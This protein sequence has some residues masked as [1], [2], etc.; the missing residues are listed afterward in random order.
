MKIQNIEKR[1]EGRGDGKVKEELMKLASETPEEEAQM[2]LDMEVL[3]MFKEW[4][5]KNKGGFDDF[6][7]DPEVKIQR[8]NLEGG[9]SVDFSGYSI[10]DLKAMFRSEVG[11]NPKSPQELVIVVKRLLKGQDKDGADFNTGGLVSTY[12]QGLRKP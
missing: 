5:K 8:I 6:L 4:Q 2:M 3:Q 12:K 9:G 11:R 10:Q 7:D 1:M